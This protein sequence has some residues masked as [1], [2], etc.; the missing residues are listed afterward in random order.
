MPRRKS[1]AT[2]DIITPVMPPRNPMGSRLRRLRERY[3][4][5]R[6][7]ISWYTRIDEGTLT[8]IEDGYADDAVYQDV[9]EAYQAA[10]EHLRNN[11]LPAKSPGRLV[12]SVISSTNSKLERQFWNDVGSYSELDE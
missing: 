5:T 2:E 9:A 11:S 8:V 10:L 12:W 1:D 3:G 6:F 7:Y 4:A